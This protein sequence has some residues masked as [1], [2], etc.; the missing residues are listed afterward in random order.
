[1]AYHI[2]TRKH[3]KMIDLL[4]K[5]V[6]IVDDDELVLKSYKR[7]LQNKGFEDIETFESGVDCIK[8]KSL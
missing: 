4:T 3:Y 8:S 1:M 2:W 5:K 6:F 7:A